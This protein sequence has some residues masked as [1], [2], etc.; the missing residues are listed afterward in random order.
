[1]INVTCIAKDLDR[2]LIDALLSC[3]TFPESDFTVAFARKVKVKPFEINQM[4]PE[5]QRTLSQ[6]GESLSLNDKQVDGQE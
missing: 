2:A 4:N 6:L 5:Y 3:H 1:M